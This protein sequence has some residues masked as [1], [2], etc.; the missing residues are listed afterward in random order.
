M[1][2]NE[3]LSNNG[4]SKSIRFAYSKCNL[5]GEDVDVYGVIYSYKRLASLDD[6]SIE[7]IYDYIVKGLNF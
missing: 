2:I 4:I 7:N 3:L 6:K 1:D 5:I